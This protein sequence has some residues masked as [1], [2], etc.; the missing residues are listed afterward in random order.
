MKTL[1]S[2]TLLLLLAGCVS[3][4]PKP[5][6]PAYAPVWPKPT[7]QAQPAAASGSI[8]SDHYAVSL[9]TDR[10]AF[11]I[12]DL[13]TVE[14]DERTQASKKAETDLSKSNS[15]SIS[16]P[17]I[18]GKTVKGLFGWEEGLGTSLS[19]NHDFEGNSESKQSNSLSGNISVTVVDVIPNGTLH[20]RGEKWLTLN[21]G[22]EFIRV[23]GLVRPDDVDTNNVVSSQRL[24]DARITYSG[25]G[26]L[27]DSNA[28]GWLSRV[29]LSPLFL[30]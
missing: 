14:L 22:E 26:A 6:D 16:D 13:I 2:L 4:P 8:Y 5:N 12:G 19:T 27:A 7:P 10:K 20:V 18:L 15:S 11:R 1:L 17:T 25:T 23:S 29:F 30:F 24:A 28:I 3:P 9:Y 21:Q